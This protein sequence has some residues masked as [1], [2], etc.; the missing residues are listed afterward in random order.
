MTLITVFRADKRR[1]ETGQ[2]IT[3]A[4]EFADRNPDGRRLEEL[5]DSSR[6]LGKPAR[7]GSLFLFEN[8]RVAELHWAKMTGGILYEC[9]INPSAIAH[10]GDMR[11]VDIAGEALRKNNDPLP[12]IGG[13]WAGTGTEKP[14]W[15]LLIA[16]AKVTRVICDDQLQRQGV[17]VG[18]LLPESAFSN[19][20]S[21]ALS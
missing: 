19:T 5:F 9:A 2:S 18:R 17:L 21:K 8:C 7:I 15:E 12:Y 1:F 13:Y 14:R 16:E 10:R 4:G 3:T 11:L 6:P 20:D